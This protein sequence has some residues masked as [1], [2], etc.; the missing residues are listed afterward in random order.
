MQEDLSKVQVSTGFAPVPA[1]VL[2]ALLRYMH[3]DAISDAPSSQ[4]VLSKKHP[5]TGGS[6]PPIIALGVNQSRGR[7]KVWLFEFHLD[8]VRNL[9]FQLGRNARRRRSSQIFVSH[10]LKSCM[11]SSVHFPNPTSQ[12][13]RR[14]RRPESFPP[15]H[16]R[17]DAMKH[18]LYVRMRLIRQQPTATTSARRSAACTYP[19]LVCL[20]VLQSIIAFEP[21]RTHV[22]LDGMKLVNKSSVAAV[23][24]RLVLHFPSPQPWPGVGS[25]K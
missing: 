21:L 3:P 7:P 10:A 22:G 8:S 4:T 1:Q 11:A 24:R 25:S 16:H 18:I 13:N 23:G 6:W 14:V 2:I 17:P 12:L 19:P 20:L 9:G 5:N 15:L